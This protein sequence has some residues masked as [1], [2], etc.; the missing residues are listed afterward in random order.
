MPVVRR[1]SAHATERPIFAPRVFQVSSAEQPAAPPAL[2]SVNRAERSSTGGACE[3]QAHDSIVAQSGQRCAILAARE[4]MAKRRTSNRELIDT[5]RN[6][7]FAKRDAARPSRRAPG[8]RA[9]LKSPCARCE[10][11]TGIDRP[12]VLMQTR[13][14]IRPVSPALP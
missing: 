11:Y 5:G 3:Q 12:T 13:R 10:G 1:S 2:P 6:K 7:M 8:P 4:A 9:W 14:A